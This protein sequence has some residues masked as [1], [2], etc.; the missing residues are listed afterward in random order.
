[1]KTYALNRSQKVL[2]LYTVQSLT[3]HRLHQFWM[4]IAHGRYCNPGDSRLIQQSIPALLQFLNC[5]LAGELHSAMDD[6]QVV[7]LLYSNYKG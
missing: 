4:Q 5:K 3:L 1:M 7:G 6:S 2:L